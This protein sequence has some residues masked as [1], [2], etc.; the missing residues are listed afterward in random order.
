MFN[1]FSRFTKKVPTLSSIKKAHKLIQ[2]HIHNT[3][4]LTNQT[5]NELVGANLF[6]KC[7]NFQKGGAFKVGL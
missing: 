5:I 6:F 1:K 2:P 3:P 7:E 4:I